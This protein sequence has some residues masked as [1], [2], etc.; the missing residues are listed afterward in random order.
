MNENTVIEIREPQTIA[1][2]INAIRKRAARQMLEDSV[3]V[4]RLLTEAKRSV[5]HGDWGGW[6]EVNFA[7]STS[8]ANN[9]MRLYEAYG[10]ADQ[11]GIFEENRMAIFGNLSKSQAIALLGLPEPQRREFV[12]SHDV[13][14]LS[15]RDMEAEIAKIK[16]EAKQAAWEDWRED[17]EN[18]QA[19]RDGMKADVK[20]LQEDTVALRTLA[21]DANRAADEAKKTAETEKKAAAI[22]VDRAKKLNADLC[23][24]KSESEEVQKERDEVKHQLYDA[25]QKITELESAPAPAAEIT[26]E[27]KAEIAGAAREEALAE[28][29]GKIAALEAEAAKLRAAA[30]PVTTKFAVQ[31]DIFQQA[32]NRMRELIGECENEEVAMKLKN[33]L[34]TAVRRMNG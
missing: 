30:D 3:E 34:T 1:A 28:S 6:L 11:I 12:E 24:V 19:D 17:Y 13:E 31:F 18:L 16:E 33:A 20:R 32:F 10:T 5:G 9:L 7:Y 26:D 29:A 14:N 4:G 8:E 23:K 22:A 25:Q 15:V 21:A 2:E 27:Q